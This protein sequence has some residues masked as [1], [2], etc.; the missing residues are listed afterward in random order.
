MKKIM[1]VCFIFL[2]FLTVFSFQINGVVVK[3]YDGDTILL[4]DNEKGQVK[5][6]LAHIDAPEKNQ[7]YGKESAEFLKQIL[8]NTKVIVVFHKID[9]YGRIIGEIYQKRIFNLTKEQININ[10]N[11][12]MIQTGNAWFY[13]EYSD[14]KEMEQKQILARK[15]KIGIW[16]KEN[17]IQPW[18]FR[19]TEKE[20]SK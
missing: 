1:F 15:N 11:E 13:K 20:K 19:K 14:K 5:I 2:M 12:Y 6:R 10:I 4:Q 17:S 18:I 16:Q 7:E 8:L 9:V 3:I